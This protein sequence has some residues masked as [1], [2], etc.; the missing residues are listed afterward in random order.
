[1]T[2]KRLKEKSERMNFG[3]KQKIQE[4]SAQL[5][6]WTQMINGLKRSQSLRFLLRKLLIL[7]M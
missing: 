7:L 6:T 1:M 5:K 2:R 3:K 4:L